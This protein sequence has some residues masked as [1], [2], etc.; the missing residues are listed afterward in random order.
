[1]TCNIGQPL[2]KRVKLNVRSMVWDGHRPLLC[3]MVEAPFEAISD[4]LLTAG[5]LH[6]VLEARFEQRVRQRA[7]AKRCKPQ[8]ECNS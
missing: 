1:M 5:L 3:S 6:I 7:K 4:A 2:D 8:T